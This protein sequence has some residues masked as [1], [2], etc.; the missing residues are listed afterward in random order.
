MVLTTE[1]W[2]QECPGH[3]VVFGAGSPEALA[4]WAPVGFFRGDLWPALAGSCVDM[5]KAHPVWG[6]PLVNGC[7]AATYS[8][9]PSPGQYHRRR[10]A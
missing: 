8:P 6:G 4:C 9:T 1:L 10:E 2:V 5:P 3:L 7:P